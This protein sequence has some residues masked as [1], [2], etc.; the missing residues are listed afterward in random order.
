MHKYKNQL[1]AGIREPVVNLDSES[2]PAKFWLYPFPKTFHSSSL[3]FCLIDCRGHGGRGP[4]P[5]LGPGARHLGGPLVPQRGLERGEDGLA[6]D[7]DVVR[8]DAVDHVA[9]PRLAHQGVHGAGRGA[10]RD[11]QPDDVDQLHRHDL[12]GLGEERLEVGR[13]LKEGVVDGAADLFDGEGVVDGVPAPLDQRRLGV[14]RILHDKHRLRQPA[15]QPAPRLGHLARELLEQRPPQE[16][17][18]HALENGHVLERA[19]A[20]AVVDCAEALHLAVHGGGV[21]EGRDHAVDHVDHLDP[22]RNT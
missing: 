16:P 2:I 11:Q 5:Q 14:A 19:H 12:L 17:H 18:H 13:D 10:D 3:F 22:H 9:H 8:G 1:G 21:V 15:P 20:V 4:V 6:H 7:R